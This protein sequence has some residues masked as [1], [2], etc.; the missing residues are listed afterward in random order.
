[1]GLIGLQGLDFAHRIRPVRSGGVDVV[2][3]GRWADLQADSHTDNNKA[4]V[5][6]RAFPQAPETPIPSGSGSGRTPA[7]NRG[8][9]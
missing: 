7:D 3:P 1:M 5:A 6:V 4:A 8:R 2:R 9:R